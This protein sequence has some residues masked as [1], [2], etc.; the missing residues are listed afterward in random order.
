ML[1]LKLEGADER[2]ATL[3]DFRIWTSEVHCCMCTVGA[4]Y[5][6]EM[7]KVVVYIEGE[8]PRLVNATTGDNW[9]RTEF[10]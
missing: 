1:H 6:I 2:S 7:L 3:A 8:F 4:S 10:K 9:T 5:I